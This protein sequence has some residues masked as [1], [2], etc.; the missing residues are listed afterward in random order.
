MTQAYKNNSINNTS[1]DILLVFLKHKIEIVT[2]SK[3]EHIYTFLYI[4]ESFHPYSSFHWKILLLD[5][6]IYFKNFKNFT[7][8]LPMRLCY[9]W[10]VP[11]ITPTI[12]QCMVYR[13][14]TDQYCW[15]TLPYLWERKRQAQTITLWGDLTWL[16]KSSPGLREYA[17]ASSHAQTFLLS[18]P[19]TLSSSLVLLPLLLKT[20]L[21]NVQLRTFG[22]IYFSASR[23]LMH[24]IL[25]PVSFAHG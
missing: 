21:F 4:L 6:N 8:D 24:Q 3:R 1:S 13:G 11:L 17:Q 23:F 16:T 2:K 14:V 9:G 25:L 15:T 5:K 20:V 10:H 7:W 19:V 18:L 22:S 12:L